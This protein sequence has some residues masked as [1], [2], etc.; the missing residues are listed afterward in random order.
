VMSFPIPAAIRANSLLP[1][2]RFP[3][4]PEIRRCFA[5]EPLEGIAEL[6]FRMDSTQARNSFVLSWA[7]IVTVYSAGYHTREGL[8]CGE[9]G[10]ETWGGKVMRWSCEP[11]TK[12]E[13]GSWT[14]RKDCC[15]VTRDTP[16]MERNWGCRLFEKSR[17]SV[18]R[19]LSSILSAE[20][21]F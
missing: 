11:R 1:P 17:C 6:R 7:G 20:R 8:E 19:S 12:V 13:Y 2:W 15:H 14:C 21:S 5:S 3:S 18:N 9:N 4:G 10:V 16:R